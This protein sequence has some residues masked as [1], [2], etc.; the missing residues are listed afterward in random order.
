MEIEIKQISGEA[1][2]PLRHGIMNPDLSFDAIRLDNDAFGTHFGLYKN[3]DLTS[4]VSLFKTG[5]SYQLRKFATE[6]SAQGKGCGSILLNHIIK[7]VRQAG[8][9]KIWCNARV[10]A[11]S[12]Y[13]KFGFAQGNSRSTA[14]GI[15]F[16]IMEYLYL[17]E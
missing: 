10:S 16:V 7:Y 13:S 2:W 17:S 15:D 14:N 8:G 1:T 12:F 3:Q 6:I 4:I 5:N 11:T 9:E